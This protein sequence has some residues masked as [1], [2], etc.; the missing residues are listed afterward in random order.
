M[1]DEASG[2]PVLF[3]RNGFLSKGGFGATILVKQLM[4]PNI[5]TVEHDDDLVIVA[6][7]LLEN[8][9]N[10]IG[11]MVNNKLIGVVSK[12]DIVRAITAIAEQ[13]KDM[14]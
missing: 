9:I 7:A 3:A 2:I 10:G 11:V 12:T 1:E 8:N 14:I 4:T 6:T 5:I 13:P